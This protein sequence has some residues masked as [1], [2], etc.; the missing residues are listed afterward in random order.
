MTF[1]SCKVWKRFE[2]NKCQMKQPLNQWN[3]QIQLWSPKSHLGLTFPAGRDSTQTRHLLR[4]CYPIETC[5][6]MCSDAGDEDAQQPYWQQQNQS[7]YRH[8]PTMGEADERWPL[9]TVEHGADIQKNDRAP[10]LMT[11]T[12]DSNI[13]LSFVFFS[14][15]NSKPIKL[16]QLYYLFTG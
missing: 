1:F 10:Y 8:P 9:H 15:A 3:R 6:W 11:G 12:K 4:G 7:R 13:L 14:K 16:N 5:T 2:K